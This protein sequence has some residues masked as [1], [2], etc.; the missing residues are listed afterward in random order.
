MYLGKIVEMGSYEKMM[1][2]SLHPYTKALINVMPKPKIKNK[3]ENG[4]SKRGKPPTL[5]IYPLDVVFTLDVRLQR[6]C[7]KRKSLKTANMVKGI[8]LPV[9]L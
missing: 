4:L 8:T 2:S 6:R 7:A 3:N 9:T 5:Q 1:N